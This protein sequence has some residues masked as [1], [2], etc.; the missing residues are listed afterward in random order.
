MR[1]VILFMHVSLDGFVCGLHD[2]MDWTVFSNT[3]KEVKWKNSCLAKAD[4][5][6]TVWKMKYAAGGNMVIFGGAALAAY[7]TKNNLVDEYRI[8]L[9]PVV[10]GNG[11]P[12]FKEV[13][14]RVNL[15]L[16]RSKAFD[17]GVTGLYYEVI[18]K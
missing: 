11:K 2:E 8:K 7:F 6:T 10:L 4:P 9:E 18:K 13:T 12:L 1:K 5:A 15:K 3:L 17:S 16:I 14:D